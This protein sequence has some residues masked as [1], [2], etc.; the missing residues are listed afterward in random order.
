FEIRLGVNSAQLGSRCKEHALRIRQ[1]FSHGYPIW[2]GPQ[3]L[4]KTQVNS[5]TILNKIR[6]AVL[7][8]GAGNKRRPLEGTSLNPLR[9]ESHERNTIVSDDI[10]AGVATGAEDDRIREIRCR[11][12]QF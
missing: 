3:L 12:C 6:V 11:I 5:L 9:F 4:R 7:K 10:V 2:V 1:S 8:A